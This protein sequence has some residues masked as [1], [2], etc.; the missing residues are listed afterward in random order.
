MQYL[1]IGKIQNL[2]FTMAFEG[3]EM[4]PYVKMENSSAK[5]KRRLSDFDRALMTLRL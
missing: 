1:D 5:E 2:T 3:I 4:T